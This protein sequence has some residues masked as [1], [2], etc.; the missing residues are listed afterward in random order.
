MLADEPAEEG[1]DGEQEPGQGQREAGAQA[2]AAS[3]RPHDSL[4][5]AADVSAFSPIRKGNVQLRAL[6]R[7]VSSFT[8]L[9]YNRMQIAMQTHTKQRTRGAVLAVLLA[10]TALG[11]FAA[12]HEGWAQGAPATTTLSQTASGAI[13]PTGTV[14]LIPDFSDLVSQVRP[15]VVSITT[16]LRATDDEDSAEGA[17]AGFPRHAAPGWPAARR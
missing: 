4:L 1:G 16:K 6:N 10:G 12:G 14:H 17:G 11:G 13:Q 3:E 2:E 5:P 15:A 7:V 8:R 9:S